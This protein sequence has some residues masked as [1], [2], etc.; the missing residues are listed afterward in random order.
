MSDPSSGPVGSSPS[1]DGGGTSAEEIQT[2]IEETRREL[3]ETVDALSAKLDVKARAREKTQ[4]TKQRAV[5]QVDLAQQRVAEVVT[6]VKD[7]AIDEHG[8]PRQA[9]L[10]A[11]GA[12]ALAIVGVL[13]LVLRERKR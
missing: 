6:G 13:L 10:V 8:H 3:G 5:A 12:A 2:H 9:V 1:S 11:A 4:E 7:A